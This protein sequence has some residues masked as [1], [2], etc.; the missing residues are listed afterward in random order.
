MTA[1]SSQTHRSRTSVGPPPSQQVREASAQAGFRHGAD[2]A[3]VGAA[4]AA[5]DAKARQALR[6]LAVLAAELLRVAI[7]ELLRLVELGMAH[8]R[9]I[10]PDAADPVAPG[11]VAVDD[12]GE[13]RGMRAVDHEVGGRP[14]GLAVGLLDRLPQGQ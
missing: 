2:V 3:V 12:V 5:E 8:S 10:G 13:V 4:A 9:G 7:V 14:A 11:I 6:K 1:A